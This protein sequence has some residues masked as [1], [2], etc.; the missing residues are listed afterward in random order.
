LPDK[1]RVNSFGITNDEPAK[2]W[3][4]TSYTK[5]IINTTVAG[6][7]VDELVHWIRQIQFYDNEM[8]GLGTKLAS[9]RLCLS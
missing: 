4:K 2:K 8:A 5:P 9:L 3:K 7:Y 6:Y 1:E